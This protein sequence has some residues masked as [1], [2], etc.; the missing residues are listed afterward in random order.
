[1]PDV[2][3]LAYVDLATRALK[4]DMD[5]YLPDLGSFEPVA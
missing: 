3:G 1:M 2:F 4:M 5:A